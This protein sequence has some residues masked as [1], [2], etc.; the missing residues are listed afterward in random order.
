LKIENLLIFP[1]S[2]S[3]AARAGV[4]NITRTLAVEWAPSG[5]RINAVAPVSLI[6]VTNNDEPEVL[7][8]TLH[9]QSTGELHVLR[10]SKAACSVMGVLTT[11]V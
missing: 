2:H 3:G 6:I 7:D 10:D 11:Y 8:V 9:A 4:E 5:I 1:V